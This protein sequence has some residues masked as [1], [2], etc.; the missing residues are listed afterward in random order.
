MDVVRGVVRT[1]LADHRA[2]LLRGFETWQRHAH[3][4]GGFNGLR[5]ALAQ[6]GRPECCFDATSFPLSVATGSTLSSCGASQTTAR[7]LCNDLAAFRLS[8]GGLDLPMPMSPPPPGDDGCPAAAA[9]D[10]AAQRAAHPGRRP[11]PPPSLWYVRD[12][13]FQ[14]QW[15]RLSFTRSP[16]QPEGVVI[17][18]LY[19]PLYDV[20]G[21]DWLHEVW[22]ERRS[23]SSH[24]GAAGGGDEPTS[25]GPHQRDSPSLGSGDDYRFVYVG[26]DRS[27]TPLHY[28]VYGTYSW[29]LNLAG[30]KT[31]HVALSAD[32]EAHLAAYVLGDSPD[33]SVLSLPPD[34]RCTSR[35]RFATVDQ[36]P[37]DLIVVPPLVL[38]QVHNRTSA[39]S[40]LRPPRHGVVSVN[41]NWADGGSALLM[42]RLLVAQA[43]RAVAQVDPTALAALKHCPLAAGSA[44]ASPDQDVCVMP[45][46]PQL[47]ELMLRG[48]HA[49]NFAS[50]EAFVM[51]A[52]RRD[53]AGDYQGALSLLRAHRDELFL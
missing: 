51:A 21:I 24:G 26:S 52:Q 18:P 13:H 41:H 6:V 42:T 10:A 11:V 53:D 43:R 3:R 20:L 49:W 2:C 30:E 9:D 22:A 16:T 28:D 37:G 4:D 14:Q 32:F 31:W 5:I 17:C 8:L 39:A 25:T 46:W 7:H 38:H 45:S 48:A 50:F 33:A 40:P 19:A 12:W 44:V 29:S 35:V 1:A 27:W 36:G 15:E 34:L 47:L 23:A